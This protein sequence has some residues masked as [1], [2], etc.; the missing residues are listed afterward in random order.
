MRG[1]QGWVWGSWTSKGV[2]GGADLPGGGPWGGR[3]RN[4]FRGELFPAGV[5]RVKVGFSIVLNG[6]AA[7]NGRYVTAKFTK[8]KR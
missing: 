1:T 4:R 8:A 5:H 2:H 3:V 6:M 7:P